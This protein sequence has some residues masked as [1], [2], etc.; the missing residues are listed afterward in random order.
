MVR[1]AVLAPEPLELRHQRGHVERA[2]WLEPERRAVLRVE[3]LL[4]VVGKIP[5][6]DLGV[7]RVAGNEHVSFV[8]PEYSQVEDIPVVVVVRGSATLLAENH[9]FHD[10]SYARFLQ[11]LH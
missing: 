6:H 8:L 1:P 9:R 7:H 2:V 11:P 3:P 10:A 5:E 4:F